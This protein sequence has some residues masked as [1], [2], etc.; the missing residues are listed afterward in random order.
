MV[1]LCFLIGF[2]AQMIDGTLG[3]AYG[4]SCNTLLQLIYGMSPLVSSALVHFSEIFTSGVSAFSHFKMKNVD[5]SL[6]WKLLI[7]GAIGGVIGA[8]LLSKFGSYLEIPVSAYLV[9]MGVVLIVKAVRNRPPKPRNTDGKFIYPIATAGG[10]LDAAG[11][12]GWGPVVTSTMLSRSDNVS[13]T[14]G[15]VNASEFFVTIAETA[16][17]SFTI[18][19][20]G[21]HWAEV[22]F[23][24]AGGVCAAPLAALL[25]KKTNRRLLL[26]LVGLLVCGLNIYK[27]ITKIF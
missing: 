8:A 17:F 4:V 13:H 23:M 2:I 18:A 15:T 20:I 19:S 21:E 25:C 27:L 16:V 11:G 24:I 12:G 3:M 22:A 5:K 14:I 7:P 26:F 6:F 1:F 10:L 9:I